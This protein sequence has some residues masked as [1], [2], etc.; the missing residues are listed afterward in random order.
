MTIIREALLAA[1]IGL[2]AT[3][4]AFA[5]TTKPPSPPAPAG[6][7]PSPAPQHNC[8]LK[9]LNACNA[10]GHC[11]PLD[12]LRGEK[13][14]VKMTV[15]LAVG[16][17]A[18]VDPDGWVEATRIVSLARTADQIIL[19]GIDSAVAW[20]LLIYEKGEVMSFSLAT[21]DGSSI[22]FGNCTVV[23]EP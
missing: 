22:G 6:S 10:D 23:N 18:G 21:A 17:V 14:P 8:L 2:V 4:G 9:T 11:A 12:N 15:N 20:Q 3:T 19:Q 7:A 13:L 1:A 16:I 5:Q